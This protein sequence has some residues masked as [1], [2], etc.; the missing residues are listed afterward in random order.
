[1]LPTLVMDSAL[2]LSFSTL[3]QN[4]VNDLTHFLEDVDIN[5]GDTVPASSIQAWYSH[6]LKTLREADPKLYLFDPTVFVAR[7]L[8]HLRSTLQHVN[9]FDI[10]GVTKSGGPVFV[11]LC[12]IRSWKEEFLS[13]LNKD[14][15]FLC[16]F[17]AT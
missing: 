13:G 9:H 6:I 1:M 5:F 16:E 8:I 2:Q 10:N 11:P 4:W 3:A 7:L 14:L 12:F 17:I 15:T